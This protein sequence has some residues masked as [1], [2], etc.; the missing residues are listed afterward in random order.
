MCGNVG[1]P[2]T[3]TGG[4]APAMRAVSTHTTQVYK[5]NEAKECVFRLWIVVHHLNSA[6]RRPKQ[7]SLP[8]ARMRAWVILGQL[9]GGGCCCCG[10]R[11]H[12]R[13]KKWTPPLRPHKTIA[14]VLQ[15][16]TFKDNTHQ[17]HLAVS[18]TNDLRFT[19]STVKL[20]CGRRHWT[21]VDQAMGARRARWMWGHSI[22]PRRWRHGHSVRTSVVVEPV[23]QSSCAVPSSIPCYHAMRATQ[24][25]VGRP[26][27][28]F[29]CDLGRRGALVRLGYCG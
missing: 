11:E 22:L 1:T 3:S 23:G 26:G 2:S 10:I 12:V 9:C 21:S 4:R 29:P 19:S 16:T 7:S 28:L 24:H 17:I 13:A 14:V 6:R 20:M 27:F 25:A 15:A 8:V 18:I 5:R